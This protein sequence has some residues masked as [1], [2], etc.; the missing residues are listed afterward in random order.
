[1][2]SAQMFSRFAL[3][4]IIVT[5]CH[6][7][8]SNEAKI[9]GSWQRTYSEGD[10]SRSK[11]GRIIVTIDHKVKE[12]FPPEGEDGRH[13][14]DDQ[15]IFPYS[16]T[17]RLEGDVLLTTLDNQPELDMYDRHIRAGTK[18]PLK[19]DFERNRIVKIDGEKSVFDDGRWL[20]RI[21]R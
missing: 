16:G 9:V 7:S 17:W 13:L 18:P 11:V 4:C 12:G 20:D 3:C 5:A 14:S 15:F 19:K 6:R 8:S 21:K 10:G 1:M 2:V